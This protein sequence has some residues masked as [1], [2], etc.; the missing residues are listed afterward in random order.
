[1][2]SSIASN[3]CHRDARAVSRWLVF[4][5]YLLKASSTFPVNKENLSLMSLEICTFVKAA[6]ETN[7]GIEGAFP[8]A[9]SPEIQRCPIGQQAPPQPYVSHPEE[10]ARDCSGYDLGIYSYSY[11]SVLLLTTHFQIGLHKFKNTTDHVETGDHKKKITQITL[12]YAN[13]RLVKG[14]HFHVRFLPPSRIGYV[15]FA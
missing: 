12:T 10:R 9:Q 6:K 1:M 7:Y 4:C 8:A 13:R 11:F 5:V 3:L 15:L 14:N 2:D